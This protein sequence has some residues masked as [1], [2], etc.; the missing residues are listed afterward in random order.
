MSDGAQTEQK[1]ERKITVDLARQKLG[2]RA[3]NMKD[4]DVQEILNSLY[5]LCEQVVK[6]V[7]NNAGKENNAD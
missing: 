4:Q 6:N 3:K 7:Y 2:D 5:F 1:F